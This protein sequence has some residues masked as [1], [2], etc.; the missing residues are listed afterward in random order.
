VTLDVFMESIMLSVASI[1]RTCAVVFAFMFVL[2]VLGVMA[3]CWA[4]Y[5]KGE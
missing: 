1:L 5:R 4:D 3:E 2:F